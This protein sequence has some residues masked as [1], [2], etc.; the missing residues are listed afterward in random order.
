MIFAPDGEASAAL[1]LHNR[2]NV[3]HLAEADQGVKCGK[4]EPYFNAFLDSGQVRVQSVHT[5]YSE[6]ALKV[7]LE[8][9]KF[10]Y[11]KSNISITSLLFH[12]S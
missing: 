1:G 4:G 2:H 10:K 12:V 11:M 3:L 6:R 8:E 7:L 5:V 9:P